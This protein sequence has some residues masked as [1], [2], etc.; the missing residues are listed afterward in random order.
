MAVFLLKMGQKQELPVQKVAQAK[1]NECGKKINT[2]LLN[3][4]AIGSEISFPFSFQNCKPIDP[5]HTSIFLAG[6]E[7]SFFFHV[8]IMNLS[9]I[10]R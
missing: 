8:K 2:Y 6:T 7:N 1:K 9:I 3:N 10:K 4:L 5:E